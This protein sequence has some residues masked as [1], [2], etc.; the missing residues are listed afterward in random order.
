M[1]TTNLIQQQQLLA[2]IPAFINYVSWHVDDY[3]NSPVAHVREWANGPLAQRCKTG[4]PMYKINGI[5]SWSDTGTGTIF[6]DIDLDVFYLGANSFQ[7]TSFRLWPDMTLESLCDR[8]CMNILGADYYIT[9]WIQHQ[10]FIS[11]CEDFIKTYRNHHKGLV[12]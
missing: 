12:I 8:L 2:A 5:E 6:T 9:N 3:I 4:L 10:D 11:V 1:L 7:R